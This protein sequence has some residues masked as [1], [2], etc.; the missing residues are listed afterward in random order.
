MHVHKAPSS[1]TQELCK[2]CLWHLWPQRLHCPL[3]CP[4]KLMWF[5]FRQEGPGAKAESTMLA[6]KLDVCPWVVC[7]LRLLAFIRVHHLRQ[8]GHSHTNDY[9]HV[10]ASSVL[11]P[12]PPP[13]PPAATAMRSCFSS[14]CTRAALLLQKPFATMRLL[15]N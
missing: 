4:S 12:P 11:T 9:C 7:I 10:G 3:P 15:S 2:L 6:K 8:L 5:A 14:L 1:T 13:P